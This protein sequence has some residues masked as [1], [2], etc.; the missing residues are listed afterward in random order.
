MA[1]SVV[2]EMNLHDMLSPKIQE[3]TGHINKMESGLNQAAERAN[4]FGR[5]LLTAIGLTVAFERAFEGIHESI[6]A[7]EKLHQAE[8]QVEAGLESTG[9]AAGLTFEELETSAASF[10]AKFKFTK[11]EIMDMQS[12]LV[13]FPAVTKATF[14]DASQ[15]IIDLA[16]RTH[17][18]LNEV[19]IMVGKAL[20]DPER[21]IT[22]LRRVGVNFNDTQT[23]IIK[24]MVETG[25]VGQA[26]AAILHELQT[27]FAGSAQAAANSDPLFK[28][29]KLMGS[30]HLQVGEVAVKIQEKFIPVLEW[31]ADAFKNTIEWIQ[32]HKELVEIVGSVLLGV[33]A[34]IAGIIVVTQVWTAVQW[35]LNIALLSNPIGLL[36]TA[37]GALVGFVIY[38]YTHFAKFRAFL[39]ATWEVIK[40]VGSIIADFFI[41]LKDVLVG[42]FTLDT[43]KIKSGMLRQA[44]A[45]F[46]SGK[47][48]ADA[49]KRGWEAG[50]ADFANDQKTV[51]A[52]K[53]IEDKKKT[54]APGEGVAM[55]PET[56]GAKGTK[57]TVVNV[58]INGGLVHDLQYMVT[59]LKESIHSIKEQVGQALVSV[60]NDSQIIAGE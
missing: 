19:S 60:V 23:E 40:E 28:Y 17:R 48:L 34:A 49:A 50:M 57:N 10:A 51:A 44:D 6:E 29:N 7:F 4:H 41:G 22:A 36:I 3:A 9:H 46:N 18:G 54:A 47:R 35:L 42:A 27:E 39:W 21:G 2:Y 30:I 59:N 1:E 14:G 15:A 25:H 8:A 56:K 45:V 16:T 11:S 52:P 12:Q 32:K 26:Q 24:K 13:T 31:L 58:T 37:I 53:K 55:K 20:Q 43:E 33:G 5:E 38:A